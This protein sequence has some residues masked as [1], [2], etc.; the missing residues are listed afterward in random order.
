L[1]SC[2]GKKGSEWKRLTEEMTNL[3]RTQEIADTMKFF[4]NG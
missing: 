1:I 3:P 4:Q 2:T